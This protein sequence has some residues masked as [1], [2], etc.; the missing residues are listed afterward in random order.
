MLKKAATE[1]DVTYSQQQLDALQEVIVLRKSEVDETRMFQALQDNGFV[2]EE[3][4]LDAVDSPW[5]DSI[6]LWKRNN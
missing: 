6:Y 3:K 2:L 1:A 4:L 5:G